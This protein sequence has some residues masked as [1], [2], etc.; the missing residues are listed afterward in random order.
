MEIICKVF[1]VIVETIHYTNTCLFLIKSSI[2]F[3]ENEYLLGKQTRQ[4]PLLMLMM[5]I[6]TYLYIRTAK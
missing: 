2:F 3:S 5:I 6:R 1:R 4:D